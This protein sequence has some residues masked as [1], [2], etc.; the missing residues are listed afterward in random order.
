MKPDRQA[1]QVIV[2]RKDLG[3]RAGK[4]VAQGAHAAI[5]AL[6]RVDAALLSDSEDG[7][8]AS[9]HSW[10]SGGQTK[11]CVRVESEEELMRVHAEAIKANLP[12]Y[13]VTDA[14]RTEF[15]GVPTRTCL[16]IGPCWSDEADRITGELR[17]L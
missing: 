4:M 13:L 5:G 3:M 17:L 8:G 10:I 15:H 6:T 16:A 7:W 9:M 11:V 14:G 12:V 2:V 1:K